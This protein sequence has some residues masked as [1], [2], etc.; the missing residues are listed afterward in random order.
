MDLVCLLRT[1]EPPICRR[2]QLHPSAVHEGLCPSHTCENNPLEQR[3]AS[4]IECRDPKT[5]RSPAEAAAQPGE[6]TAMP[7]G[8]GSLDPAAS[9]CCL[10]INQ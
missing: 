2:P 6:L 9:F 4:G 5:R 1:P 7:L 8:R 10:M 3:A